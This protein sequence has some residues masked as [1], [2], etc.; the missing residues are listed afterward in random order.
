MERFDDGFPGIKEV[1]KDKEKV[2]KLPKVNP[3]D[4][5]NKKINKLPKFDDK[6]KIEKEDL[7]EFFEKK[8]NK[9][10]RERL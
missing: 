10:R 7:G 3:E 4:K 9:Q 6:N 1:V 8:P 2:D 5:I